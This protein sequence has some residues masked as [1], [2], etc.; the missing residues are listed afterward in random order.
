M[1]P[2]ICMNGGNMTRSWRD[3]QQFAMKYVRSCCDTV[4]AGVEVPFKSSCWVCCRI[5]VGKMSIGKHNNDFPRT[6]LDAIR[7]Y[8]H[9]VS[10]HLKSWM[11]VWGTAKSNR[12][13]NVF[14]AINECHVILVRIYLKSDVG[15][16]RKWNVG[17][18]N[19]I[20]DNWVHCEHRNKVINRVVIDQPFIS[21][22][23]LK[24]ASKRYRH[25]SVVYTHL[26]A[27]KTQ[28]SRS[29]RNGKFLHLI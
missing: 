12:H 23:S 26:K 20:W 28:M 24:E 9:F 8:K 22:T 4:N 27:N 21:L 29:S 13:C 18:L 16:K 19:S 2:S 25:S 5:G 17:T 14:D 11:H 15:L 10:Y 7:L 1:H 3:V 6:I